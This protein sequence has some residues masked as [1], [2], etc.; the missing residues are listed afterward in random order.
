MNTWTEYVLIRA[1][2]YAPGEQPWIPAGPDDQDLLFGEDV[3]LW[4]TETGQPIMACLTGR[5]DTVGCHVESI[6]LTPLEIGSG[7]V[8]FTILG[9]L[10]DSCAEIGA[11]STFAPYVDD[12]KRAIDLARPHP[13][14]RVVGFLTLWEVAF[15]QEGQYAALRLLGIVGSD[16]AQ[17]TFIPLE[18]A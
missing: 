2:H 3:D 11:T 4:W 6:K 13:S 15:E 17:P 12:I 14:E 9:F 16:A 10:P 18:D 8:I 1:A 7:D 5:G